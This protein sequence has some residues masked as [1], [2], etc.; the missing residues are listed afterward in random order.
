M[1]PTHD[2]NADFVQRLADV[3]RG[4]YAYILQLL[5]NRTDADDVLQATNLVMWSKRDDFREGSDFAAWAGKIAYFEVLGHRKRAQRN[6]LRFGDTLIEQLA[7]EGADDP[8]HVDSTLLLLRQCMAKLTERDRDLIR[9]QY[10]DDLKPRDI[11]V[12]TGRTAGAIAQTMHRIRMA[13]LK[14]IDSNATP[15]REDLP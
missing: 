8:A 14:C 12:Q 5:P 7:Q 9:L 2:N 1:T 10:A 3:Q 4:L 11:A 6:K 13:L 15:P